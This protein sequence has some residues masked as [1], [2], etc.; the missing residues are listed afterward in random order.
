MQRKFVSRRYQS[1][2]DKD[3]GLAEFG[4]KAGRWISLDRSQVALGC[5]EILSSATRQLL[6][7]RRGHEQPETTFPR[8]YGPSRCGVLDSHFSMFS[9]F[10]SQEFDGFAS[11]PSGSFAIGDFACCP[12]VFSAGVERLAAGVFSNGG[13]V[14]GADA[15]L[16]AAELVS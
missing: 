2:F 3:A 7:E 8:F 14:V 5:L 1:A 16:A 10:G 11:V 12:E 13:V 9:A 6:A 4:S 15:G